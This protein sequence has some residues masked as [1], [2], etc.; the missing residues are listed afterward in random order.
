M[1][2]II[3]RRSAINRL[4]PLGGRGSRRHGTFDSARAL[5]NENLEFLAFGNPLVNG[6]V[7]RCR[8]KDFGGL[9]GIKTIEHYRLLTGMIFH[10][11]V[12]LRA[13]SEILELVPVV[14][15]RSNGVSV[16]EIRALEAR[17]LQCAPAARVNPADHRP[18]IRRISERADYY[19][20][21]AGERILLKAG[22]MKS[23][24]AG[25]I[26]RPVES[27]LGK[28]QDSYAKKLK[29]LE[30]QLERQECQMKWFDKDMKSAMTRTKNRIAEV[31]REHAV[32]MDKYRGYLDV[33]ATITLVNAGILITHP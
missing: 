21:E 3:G 32:T 11:L 23:R 12:R 5:E 16:D 14:V 24:V 29:E 26:A 7:R 13:A 33:S 20:A 30:E 25:D 2:E 31:K 8:E 17:A 27:E 9:T 18:D 15:I 19:F 6:L 28:I 4:Y 10:Y 22:E 1:D